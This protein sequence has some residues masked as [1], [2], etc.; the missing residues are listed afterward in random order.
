MGRGCLPAP[1]QKTTSPRQPDESFNSALSGHR[2]A[3]PA[4]SG[5]LRPARQAG[6]ALPQRGH[7]HGP[8]PPGARLGHR[9]CGAGEQLERR[10]SVRAAGAPALPRPARQPRGPRPRFSQQLDSARGPGQ[11]RPEHRAL[12][13]RGDTQL[14]SFPSISY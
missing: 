13:P 4:A 7:K 11:P 10:R 9:P 5:R 12:L 2:P 6:R 3:G 1:F 8:P 14:P